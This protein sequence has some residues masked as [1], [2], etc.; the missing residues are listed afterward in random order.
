MTTNR[1]FTSRCIANRQKMRIY[2]TKL[3]IKNFKNDFIYLYGKDK[4]EQTLKGIALW[5]Y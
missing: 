2:T 3:D 1:E 4:I 5:E